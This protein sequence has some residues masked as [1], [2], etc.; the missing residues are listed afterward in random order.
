[1][2]ANDGL[3][4]AERGRCLAT[5]R[6]AC[7][8]SGSCTE[9]LT[10]AATT[11]GMTPTRCCRALFSDAG[12][13]CRCE[14]DRFRPLSGGQ[15]SRATRRAATKETP[16]GTQ[17]SDDT[18]TVLQ[19]HVALCM[20]AAFDRVKAGNAASTP[21]PGPSRQHDPAPAARRTLFSNQALCVNAEF[22]YVKV[23]DPASG[24]CYVLAE[25]RLGEL[26]GAL[27]K[28]AK[29][30]KDAKAA[31]PGF[32]VRFPSRSQLHKQLVG[33]S[34][35]EPCQVRVRWQTVGAAQR[36]CKGA[37]LKA[38]KAASPGFPVSVSGHERL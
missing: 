7:R 31:S 36:S 22:D 21:Q 12:L 11:N 35:Q 33:A 8:V 20:N 29:K 14:P 1:M 24:R 30:G 27:P 4:M 5:R 26:P 15:A 23:Q 3:I 17:Q 34:C 32:T 28:A 37:L 9:S 13:A 16:Q 25:A 38:A 2:P 18:R 10:P 19:Q 6:C